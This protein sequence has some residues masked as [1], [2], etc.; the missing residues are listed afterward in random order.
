MPLLRRVSHGPGLAVVRFLREGSR[1]PWQG[2]RLEVAG[3]QETP[4][5]V[6]AWVS[7]ELTG[8]PRLS[9]GSLWSVWWEM[10]QLRPP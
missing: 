1:E 8:T 9:G 10:Q 4:V 5:V 6:Q 7:G 2:Q 3:G